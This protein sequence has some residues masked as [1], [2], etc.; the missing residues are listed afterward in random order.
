MDIFNQIII[1][2]QIYKTINTPYYP[3]MM[4]MMIN[5]VFY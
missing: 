5:P 3:S 2:I 4:M 1:G